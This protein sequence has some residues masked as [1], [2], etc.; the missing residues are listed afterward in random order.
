MSAG[1]PRNLDANER[2]PL[3][4]TWLAMRQRCY[5]PNATS[6]KN[7]GARGIKVC[8]RWQSFRNFVMD[9][10]LKPTPEHWIERIDNDGDYDPFNC[11]W[12]LPVQQARNKRI[13]APKPVKEKPQK[14][15]R[16]KFI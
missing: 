9:M 12:A 3:Y 5:N 4:S 14:S 16:T 11:I 7:Y 13:P 6:F 10:G 15:W 8:D 2:H 1:R